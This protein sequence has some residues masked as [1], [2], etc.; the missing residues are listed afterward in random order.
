MQLLRKTKP[1]LTR[2]QGRYK[3][4]DIESHSDRLVK[5]VV[6]ARVGLDGR[7]FVPLERAWI[8]VSRF[9]QAAKP[10]NGLGPMP[11]HIIHFIACRKGFR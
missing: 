1:Y 6:E 5:E 2:S 4:K 3:K 8:E 11:K 7:V 10:S 9:G